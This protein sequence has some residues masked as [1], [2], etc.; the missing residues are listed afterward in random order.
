MRHRWIPSK[1]GSDKYESFD[2]GRICAGPQ[3]AVCH[4][5]FCDW[6]F[7]LD[8]LPDCPGAPSREK[9]KNQFFVLTIDSVERSPGYQYEGGWE[10]FQQAM[11]WAKRIHN[12]E[13]E[14]DSDDPVPERVVVLQVRE[15]LE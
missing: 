2:L 5:S 9:V 10:T 1:D 7:D 11:D 12:D 14:R 13:L 3:C 6:C 15:V 4:Q 8:E